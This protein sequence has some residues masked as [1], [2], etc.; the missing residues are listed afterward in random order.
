MIPIG[1]P[2]CDNLRVTFPLADR[3]VAPPIREVILTL[4]FPLGLAARPDGKSW[5]VGPYG[6]VF[7][8]A[9]SFSVYSMQFSGAA[10]RAI[11]EA[12]LMQELCS[13]IDMTTHNITRLDASCD[14]AVAAPPFLH[15]LYRRVRRNG[16]AIGKK[17]VTH[18]DID[19]YVSVNAFGQTVQNI[20]LGKRTSE[21]R[22]YCYDKRHERLEKGGDDPGDCL[23]IEVRLKSQVGC[24]VWDA[25]APER[26][27][28]HYAAPSL[29]GLPASVRSWEPNGQGFR[30][31][32]LQSNFTPYARM[33]LLVQE[34]PVIG[35]L[36]RL[37]RQDTS[38]GLDS[39]FKLIQRRFDGEA[40]P[41]PSV[42]S[43]VG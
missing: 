35:Q 7:Y 18:R 1:E 12:G 4:L 9:R 6:G 43:L 30:V 11:R 32:Q 25:F 2:F 37:A 42:P 33:L 14:Y 24:T 19:L 5:D 34:S 8:A 13:E 26:V 22:V 3:D 39:V 40:L 41:V 16:I 29:V 15:Q 17:I 21:I 28:Y 27:Y 10:L 38:G 23:R 20:Y 31:E 36:L